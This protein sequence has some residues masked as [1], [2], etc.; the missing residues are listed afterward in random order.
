MRVLFVCEGNKMRSPMAEALYNQM[1][2]DDGATSAGSDPYPLGGEFAETVDVMR[3][4][5]IKLSHGSQLVTPQMVEQAEKVIVFPTPSMPE[6]VTDNPKSEVWDVADPFY[7]SGDRR[8]LL[9]RARD[10]ITA[11]I[12]ELLDESRTV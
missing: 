4:I 12:K 9:R 6:F 1:A 10:D 3:E 5:G 7:Q 2:A 8:A 11:R